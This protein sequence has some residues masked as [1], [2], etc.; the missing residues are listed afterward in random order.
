[1]IFIGHLSSSVGIVSRQ[2]QIRYVQIR[3]AER[4]RKDQ[5]GGVL[6]PPSRAKGSQ[7]LRWYSNGDLME[8]RVDNITGLNL[9]RSIDKYRHGLQHFGVSIGVVCIGTSFVVPQADGS[10]IDSAGTA[11]RNFVL[12]AVLLAK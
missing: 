6:T 12:K 4:M 11:E 7:P 5:E 1:M 2:L 8:G 10:H 3:T 9:G